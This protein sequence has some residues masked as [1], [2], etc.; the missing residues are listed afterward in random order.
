[1]QRGTKAVVGPSRKQIADVV[2]SLPEQQRLV[3]KLQQEEELS[4]KEIGERLGI[5]PNTV[6]NH[7]VRAFAAIRQHLI[8]H[9]EFWAVLLVF[10]FW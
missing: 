9:G 2:N 1:M 10:V 6:R 4:Y 7:L 8:D 5:S 3:Y